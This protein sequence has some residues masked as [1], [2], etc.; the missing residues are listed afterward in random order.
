MSE[1]LPDKVIGAVEVVAE[2]LDADIVVYSG[3]IRGGADDRFI[4]LIAEK[5]K[6]KNIVLFLTTSGGLPDV[7]FRIARACQEFYEGKFS[8][9]VDTWCKS[10]GSLVA[11]GAN[12]IVMS[13]HAEFGPLDI[14]MTSREE[15]GERD[16]GLVPIQAINTLRQQSFETF[17]DFFSRLRFGDNS[18]STKMAADTAAKMTIGLF[19]EVFRQ[20][21]PMRLGEMQRAMNIGLA[22]GERLATKNVKEYA[23]SKLIA[24]YPS[25]SFVI[26]RLE[27]GN[28]FIDVRRTSQD[29]ANMIMMLRPLTQSGQAGERKGEFPQIAFVSKAWEAE[30]DDTKPGVDDNGKSNEENPPADKGTEPK[31]LEATGNGQLPNPSDR[32]ASK[33]N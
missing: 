2:Q 22:Y 20:I 9:I 10:A 15:V 13:D 28:L 11:V 33:K 16:S 27:A 18:F 24:G 7:A 1:E 4:D 3:G 25:H 5:Q 14:Q 32:V 21:D 30:N 23:I 31:S 8:L 6:R 17:D 19:N 26:D 12:E 29:E